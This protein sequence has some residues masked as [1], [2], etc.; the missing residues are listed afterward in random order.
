MLRVAYKSLKELIEERFPKEANITKALFEGPN[1]VVYTKNKDFF[2]NG[3]EKI[4][5][6]VSEL[7]KRIVIRADPSLW[8]EPEK[9]KKIIMEIVPKEAEIKKIEF[10]PEFSKVLI[11]ARKPGIVIGKNGETLKKIKEMTG[12]SPEILRMPIYSSEVVERAREIL[13]EEAKYRVKFLNEIGEKIKFKKGTKEGWV[14][15]SFLGSAREVGRS[16]IL[17]QTKESRVLL[18]CGESMSP[19]PNP[20]PYL[21]APEFDMDCLDAVVLTHA[22]LD[23]SGFIPFLYEYGYKGPLYLTAPTRDLMILLQLDYIDIMQKEVGEAPYSSKGIKNAIKHSIA[24]EYGEVCDITPDMRLTFQNAG[25]ILGSAMAHIHV[26]EGFYNILYTGDIKYGR[27]YLFEPAYT[28]FQRAE[29]VI[30]ESTYGGKNDIM[31]PLKEAQENLINVIK[32]TIERKGKVIIPSFAVGRSQE[33]MMV[34]ADRYRKKEIDVPVYLDGMIWESTIIHT[35]YPE[36]LSRYLQKLIFREDKN[37]FTNE[38]FHKVNNASERANIIDDPE[39]AIIITTSGMINGGPV[40]EYLKHLAPDEKNT[41][42]FV[43]YQAEGTLGA[44][45]QKGWREIPFPGESGEKKVLPINMEVVTV[46]GFSGHSDR[47]QLINFISRLKSKPHKIMLNHG[48]PSKS[49]NLAATLHRIHRVE[50]LVPHNL[51]AY[52]LR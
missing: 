23:H 50:T 33:I 35:T 18:D 46:E 38:I 31:P 41:L 8:I 22:H 10:E 32:K 30:M 21:D 28:N 47:N 49:L 51:D 48:E 25:H 14:R 40:M 17:I 16:C 20:H 12:W 11:Y 29:T 37:P 36:F 44:K 13:H 39:P 1:I 2:V 34:L 5:D 19:G 3:G 26:G 9:A 45:I 42:I 52:R 43:G 24:L 4:K 15:V 7:R 27:S 6:I